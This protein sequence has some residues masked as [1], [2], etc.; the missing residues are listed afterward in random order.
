MRTPY[1]DSFGVLKS[2][3]SKERK[4]WFCGSD[5]FLEVHHAFSGCFRD[6]ATEDGLF[7]LVCRECH[8]KL[9]FSAEGRAMSDKLRAEAQRKYEEGHS[10]EEFMRRYGRNWI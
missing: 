10:R 3:V 8:S 4:C 1:F 5:R 7:V 9:H 2:S 6:K